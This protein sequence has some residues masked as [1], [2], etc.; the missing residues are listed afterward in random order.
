MTFANDTIRRGCPQT[1]FAIGRLPSYS[2]YPSLLNDESDGNS[3]PPRL[4]HPGTTQHDDGIAFTILYVYTLSFIHVPIY[5]TPTAF[6]NTA[7][8]AVAGPAASALY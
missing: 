5:R 8:P 1:T 4:L 7:T 6:V 2:Y 3:W